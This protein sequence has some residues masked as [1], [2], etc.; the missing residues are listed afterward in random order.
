MA[1]TKR[2]VRPTVKVLNK[3]HI[4]RA[5]ELRVIVKGGSAFIVN[6]R[7]TSLDPKKKVVIVDNQPIG[8]AKSVNGIALLIEEYFKKVRGVE[9]IA[10]YPATQHPLA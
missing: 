3:K 6:I 10:I 4:E 5:R 9:P 8:S 7:P 2:K 1:E